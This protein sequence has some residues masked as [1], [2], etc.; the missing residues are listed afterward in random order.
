MAAFSMQRAAFERQLAEI[1]AKF[2]SRT[3][4]FGAIENRAKRQPDRELAASML[5]V[6]S[7]FD[8]APMCVDQ[9]LDERQADAEASP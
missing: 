2:Q 1:Q 4:F 6:A 3:S 5:A 9:I 7:D 8:K